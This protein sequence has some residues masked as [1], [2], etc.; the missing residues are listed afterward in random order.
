MITRDF[1]IE[2]VTTK[3]DR[4]CKGCRKDINAGSQVECRTII[5]NKKIKS[6]Y[7]CDECS[8]WV[9]SHKECDWVAA[10]IESNRQKVVGLYANGV[11]VKNI[12]ERLGITVNMVYARMRYA[13]RVL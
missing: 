5:R 10:I 2:K 6:V 13:K 12:A 1:K 11:P 9:N 8:K 3:K 7:M 4:R